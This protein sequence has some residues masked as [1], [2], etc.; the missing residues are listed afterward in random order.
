MMA[1]ASPHAKARPAALVTGARRGIG[2]AIAVALARQGFDVIVNDL[3]RDADADATLAEAEAAGGRAVF[4]AG[5]VA[6]LDGHAGLVDAAWAA[7]DG[8]DCLVNNAGVSVAQRGDLLAVT[9]DSYDRLLRINLRGPFFLT[10]AVAR[11][12][13]A[14][15]DGRIGRSI[16][17]IASANAFAASPDRGEYCLSKVGV[18]M[19][20]RLYALRLGGHG[21]AVHEVR[22]GVIRTAMTAVARERYDRRIAEGL[23]PMPRWGEPEDVG[24]TVAALAGGALPFSTGDAFHVDGGLHIH[25]L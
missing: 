22:P 12:M 10:Q 9:P 14:A 1:N 23:T 5:D 6:D 15:G 19:M 20:T 18:S 16:V 21:I 11:R 2:R 24:R 8:L 7:F 3:E 13:L 17:N 4:V 25:R